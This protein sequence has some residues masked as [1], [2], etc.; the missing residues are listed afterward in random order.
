M[1]GDSNKTNLDVC[2][3][4]LMLHS[5]KERPNERG[6]ELLCASLTI[7]PLTVQPVQE[8]TRPSPSLHDACFLHTQM[9]STFNNQMFCEM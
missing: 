3:C 5:L 9:D 8:G 2:S 1:E 7:W 4:I 6:E